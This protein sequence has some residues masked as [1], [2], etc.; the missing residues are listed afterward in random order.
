MTAWVST[1]IELLGGLAIFVGA[2][3]AVVS[4]PLIAMMLV[5]MF[6]V[7]LRYGFSSINTIGLSSDGPLFGPPGY[8]VNLLYIAS[9]L[10]LILLG[11]GA[12]SIDALLAHRTTHS[13]SLDNAPPHAA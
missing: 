1:L 2:F 10:A 12:L 3:I 13:E 5:A 9:L 8:E 11:A 7:H 6:K 4:I